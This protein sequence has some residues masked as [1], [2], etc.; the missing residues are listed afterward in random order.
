MGSTPVP[1]ASPTSA[2]PTPKTFKKKQQMNGIRWLGVVLIIVGTVAVGQG[3]FS[4]I[5]PPMRPRSA[6]WSCR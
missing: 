6:R 1:Y 2:W 5:K 4:F 3:S